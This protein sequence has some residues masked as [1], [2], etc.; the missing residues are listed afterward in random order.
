MVL[1]QGF[2]QDFNQEICPGLQSSEGSLRAEAHSELK[3]HSA[4]VP[5]W[6]LEGAH[7][8]LSRAA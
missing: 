6:L 5:P 7:S 2:S 4:S 3:A 1:A 8:F